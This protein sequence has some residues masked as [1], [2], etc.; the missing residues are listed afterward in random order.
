ML[1]SQN[2][3]V[4]L[5]LA[6]LVLV[7]L[8]GPR[9]GL[10]ITVGAGLGFGSSFWLMRMVRTTVLRFAQGNPA[11]TI[12]NPDPAVV[13][14]D[15]R[16]RRRAPA[17]QSILLSPSECKEGEATR[18]MVVTLSGQRTGDLLTD[19]T[20][21]AGDEGDLAVESEEIFCCW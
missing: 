4:T 3:A 1:L 9:A 17:N 11:L 14:F 7:R 6:A 2:L 13:A 8:R 5:T 15:G 21:G 18:T 19:T 10:L 12:G 20:A 16:G